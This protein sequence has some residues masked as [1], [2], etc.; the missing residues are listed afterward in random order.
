MS[1]LPLSR[2]EWIARA[3]ATIP[4]LSAAPLG[5]LGRPGRRCDLTVAVTDP[6]PTPRPG[7]DA[8]RVL[9]SDRIDDEPDVK[10][11]FDQVRRIPQIVDGIRCHCGCGDRL[12]SLLGCFEGEHAMALHC[13]VCQGQGRLA[14]RL[15]RDGKTLDEIRTAIDARYG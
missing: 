4:L 9:A 15:H 14:Y 13:R 6:H 10:A 7:I 5:L 3:I 11:A 1:R 12:Y 2:R 8:S